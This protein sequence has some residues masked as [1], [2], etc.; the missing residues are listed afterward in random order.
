M[1]P[2]FDSVAGKWVYPIDQDQMKSKEQRNLKKKG[3][4]QSIKKLLAKIGF[5]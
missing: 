5:I 4:F 3:F 1:A 2:V